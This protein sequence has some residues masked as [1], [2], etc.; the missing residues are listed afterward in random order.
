[1]GDPFVTPDEEQAALEVL[2]KGALE[3][4]FP[5]DE[6][7]GQLTLD[8]G[9]RLQLRVLERWLERGETLGGWKV[10]MTSG[11]ARDALGPGFRPFGFILS[12]RVHRSGDVVDPAAI[13]SCGVEPELCFRMGAVLEGRYV[14]SEDAAAAVDAVSPGFEINEL[15][16]VGSASGALRVADDLSQWGIVVG[17][18]KSPVPA[19]FDFAALRVEMRENGAVAAT[20]SA[21]DWIDD[22]YVSIA[23]LASQLSRFGLRLEPGQ[24]VITGAYSKHAV[25]G[26]GHWEAAFSELGTVSVRF[27]N[28][29]ER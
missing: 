27:D 8:E 13:T 14:Q 7:R 21:R 10:G 25:R 16:P 17:E 11:Q 1:M 9:L 20:T 3:G 19:D 28:A 23:R 29:G 26:P 15:R 5:A 24:R 2:W 6:V 12:S 18:E 22:P 4:S